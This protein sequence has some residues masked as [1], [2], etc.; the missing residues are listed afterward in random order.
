MERLLS[1]CQ[2]LDD[3]QLKHKAEMLERFSPGLGQLLLAL[4][5]GAAGL[6]VTRL[7]SRAPKPLSAG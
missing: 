6:G 1:E 2:N 7:V 3:N 4:L 5:I